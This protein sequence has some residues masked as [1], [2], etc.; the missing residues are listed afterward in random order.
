LQILH[1]ITNV[2][3]IV[4]YIVGNATTNAKVRGS[5]PHFEESEEAR[6][7]GSDAYGYH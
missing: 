6:A 4:R 1:D 3:E 5:G 2:N 7:P